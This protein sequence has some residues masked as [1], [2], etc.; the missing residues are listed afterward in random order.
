M[1][2][3]IPA[4]LVGIVVQSIKKLSYSLQHQFAITADLTCWFMG[5]LI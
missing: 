5:R 2:M 1:Q 4:D 3:N